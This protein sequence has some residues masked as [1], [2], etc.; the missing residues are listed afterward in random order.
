[1]NREI[2]LYDLEQTALILLSEKGVLYHNQTGGNFCMQPRAKG[3][4][5]PISND[6]PL[7]NLHEGSLAFK[8]SSITENRV[9][10]NLADADRIDDLLNREL[11]GMTVTV[12][13]EQL[14]ISMEAWLFV[15]VD[16]SSEVLPGF[17]KQKAI[18]TWPNSD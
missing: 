16:E 3:I 7:A 12:D 2:C 14:G 10:L 17:E 9:G 4:L 13:R 15:D 18:L 8:L 5:V 11:H 1:M 6:P